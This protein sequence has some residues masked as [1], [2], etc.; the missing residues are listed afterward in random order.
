LLNAPVV[1]SSRFVTLLSGPLVAGAMLALPPMS[2]MPPAA[3]KATA[4]AAWMAIWWVTEAVPL[5]ATALLP[6]VLLPLLGILPVQATAAPYSNP[7]I[8]LFLGGFLLA[9][10]FEASGLHRRLALA[11][12]ARS[13]TRPDRIIAAFMVTAAFISLWVSNTATTLMLYPLALS[14]LDQARATS[15]DGKASRDF[16]VALLLAVAYAATIGGLGTLIGTPPNALLAAYM[17]E[18]HQ[19]T[20]PFVRWMLYGVPIVIVAL[21]ITWWLL[22]RV[23]YRVP[24][25]EL[26]L[27]REAIAAERARLGPMRR[28]EV[29]VAVVGSITALAWMFQPL[30]GRL[31]PALSDSTISVAAG[32]ALLVIPIDRAGTRTLTWEQAERIPWGVLILFGGGLAVAAAI[33]DSGLAQWIG[34]AAGGLRDLPP[35]ALIFSLTLLVVVLTEFTSNTATAATFLPI[36]ASMA[37][38]AGVDPLVLAAP[39]ALAATSGFMLPAG[40]PPNAIIY[41]SGRLAIRDMLRAGIWVDLL[42]TVVITIATLTIMRPALGLR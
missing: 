19:V 41:A 26:P 42:L 34:A 30:L 17:L 21:P 31:V 23:L 40:T 28:A 3:W 24:V 13:G 25:V 35:V 1:P 39:A 18:S 5:S 37:V 7:V 11:M 38:G 29:T 20:I 15:A 32:L 12:I 14:V 36:V 2:G 6:L 27:G 16:E 10:A 9:A 33:Q 22:A 4:V 8:F